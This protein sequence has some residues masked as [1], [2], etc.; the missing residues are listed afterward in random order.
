MVS[1][2]NHSDGLV[3]NTLEAEHQPTARTYSNYTA[4]QRER[5]GRNILTILNIISMILTSSVLEP[6]FLFLLTSSTSSLL[7]MNCSSSVIYMYISHA[8][9]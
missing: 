4:D 6:L 7:V 9:N 8:Q 2:D 3:Q 1:R 5:E